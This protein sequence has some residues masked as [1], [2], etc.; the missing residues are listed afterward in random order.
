[1]EL[2]DECL[3]TRLLCRSTVDDGIRILRG[4]TVDIVPF[5]VERTRFDV[6]NGHGVLR[7]F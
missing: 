6:A 7:M 3:W 5:K 4:N 2:H 1:M